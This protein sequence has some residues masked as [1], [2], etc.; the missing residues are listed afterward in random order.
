ML[1]I[2]DIYITPRNILKRCS[3]TRSVLESTSCKGS[4]YQGFARFYWPIYWPYGIAACAV[5]GRLRRPRE[6]RPCQHLNVGSKSGCDIRAEAYRI[7]DTPSAFKVISAPQHAQK[8]PRHLISTIAIAKFSLVCGVEDIA[9]FH[10][11]KGGPPER[12]ARCVG[13]EAPRYSAAAR[14]LSL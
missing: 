1:A 7:R 3:A 2:R 14:N 9:L 5:S 10:P 11:S 4:L 12:D 8:R 6:M 13:N